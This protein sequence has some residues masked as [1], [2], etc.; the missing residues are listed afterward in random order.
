MII[1]GFQKTTLLDFP[2]KVAC[3]LFLGGCNLRCPFC[4]N[5]SLVLGGATEAHT[6][7]EILNF[8]KKR[9]GLL[10]GVCITGGEPLLRPELKEFI[11]K[12]KELGFAVK[13]D[14][15]GCYPEK[16]KDLIKDNLIDYVAMDVKNSMEKYGVTVGIKDFDTTAVKES[17][18]FLIKGNVDYEFRTTVCSPLHTV[19]DIEALARSVKGAKKYFIQNFVDSGDLIGDG[20]SAHSG[21]ILNQMLAAAKKYVPE[22]SLRGV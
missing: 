22:T 10:D 14:T 8:L 3:T 2:G 21:E 11:A 16:L 15:N 12:I 20:L 13:L 19:E 4:H 18:D 7:E 1:N 5:A 6:E 17:I 9:Q